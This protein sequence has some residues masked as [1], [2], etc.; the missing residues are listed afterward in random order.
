LRGPID[1][2]DSDSRSTSSSYQSSTL[3]PFGILREVGPLHT[4]P[5]SAFFQGSRT[6]EESLQIR[7]RRRR[8]PRPRHPSWVVHNYRTSSSGNVQPSPRGRGLR[9][10]WSRTSQTSSFASYIHVETPARSPLQPGDLMYLTTL[11]LS[12]YRYE[13]HLVSNDLVNR[14][15]TVQP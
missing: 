5:P 6:A 11:R 8:P 14:I 9:S 1:P 13:R 3:R 4:S 12:R 2:V 10:C 15:P 7:T